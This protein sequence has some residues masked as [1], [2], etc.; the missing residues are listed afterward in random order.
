MKPRIKLAETKTPDGGALA[1]FEQDNTYSITYKGQQLMHSKM[2]AS[3]DAF[4]DISFLT[5]LGVKMNDNNDDE[6]EYEDLM[7]Q[8]SQLAA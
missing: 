4:K 7:L 2:S 3:E 1:L 5:E 8:L 6:T